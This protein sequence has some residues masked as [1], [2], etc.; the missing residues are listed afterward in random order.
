ME[1][2]P[3]TIKHLGLQM[4]STLPP[5]IGELVSNAWDADATRVDIVIPTT[6]LTDQSEI[7][8]ADDGFGMSDQTV[9]DAYLIVGRDRR[10]EEQTDITPGERKLM[11]R[12]GIGKFCGFGIATEIELETFHAGEISRFVM[13]H[14]ELD[15][16]SVQRKLTMPALDPSG[17]LAKGTRITLRGITKFRK[18]SISIDQ[19]RRGLARRFS[20]IGPT[21]GFQVWVN[22]S[23]ITIQER[24]L[25]LLLE[26]DKDGHL[27]LWEFHDEEIEPNTGWKVSGWIGA[28]EHT[29]QLEDGI[30]RGIVIMARGKLVQEPFVFD[31]VSGQQY[32]FSYLVGEI[33]AE[34]VDETEDTISTAR[35]S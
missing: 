14:A 3:G 31:A 2:D 11:G 4:Y 10:K 25:K 13:S 27:Y 21:F 9:R 33:N 34:F 1:F 28:L 17:T 7:T 32:A 35:N 12:K 30:Q 26:K 22:G 16:S 23:P 18:K 19:V 15:K 8:V 29:K 20:I 6:L 5:V 24:N